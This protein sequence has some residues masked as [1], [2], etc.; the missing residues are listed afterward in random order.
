VEINVERAPPPAAFDFARTTRRRHPERS[1]P[2]AER[3][4]ALSLTK[5]ICTPPPSSQLVW[6]RA[7]RPLA[8]AFARVERTL[9]SAAFDV[10]FDLA[11]DN[12]PDRWCPIFRV[13]CEKWGFPPSARTTVEERRFSTAKG[14]TID[15]GFGS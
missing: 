7:T 5:G 4:P 14:F 12:H 1:R 6:K 15:G 2:Q 11:P 9:L 13:L 3:E 8:F 10:D